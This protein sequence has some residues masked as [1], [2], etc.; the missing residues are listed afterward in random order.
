MKCEKVTRNIRIAGV[1]ILVKDIPARVCRDC[2]EVHFEGRFL[3]DLEEE[4]SE[5]EK[6]A[7]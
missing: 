7:A 2:G 5:R 3:L 4:L 6:Q 1:N